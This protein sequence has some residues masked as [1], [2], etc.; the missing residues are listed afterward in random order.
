MYKHY[1]YFLLCLYTIHML[2][3]L[4]S[5]YLFLGPCLYML[6]TCPISHSFGLDLQLHTLLNNF[7][8]SPFKDVSLYLNNSTGKLSSSRFFLLLTSLKTASNYSVVTLSVPWPVSS[9]SCSLYLSLCSFSFCSYIFA[10]LFLLLDE[11]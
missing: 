5:L 7:R 2:Q 11:S 3:I 8:I 4:Q 1:D 6:I 10:I 9:F